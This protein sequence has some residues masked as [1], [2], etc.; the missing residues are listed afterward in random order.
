MRFALTAEQRQF[1]DAVHD[2]LARADVPAAARAWAAGDHAPALAI[3]RALAATG[4]PAL[5]V[6]GSCGGLGAHPV[7]LV[8]ACEELGHHPLPGPV[9]ESVAAVPA[10]LATLRGNDAARDWLAALAGGEL[11]ATLAIPPLLP[12]ALDADAAGLVLLAS[13][14][15][16]GT[17]A[18]WQA[19][20]RAGHRS[21]DRARRLFDVYPVRAVEAEPGGGVAAATTAATRYGTLASA[22][23]LLGAGRGLLD[24]AVTH[25]KTREQFGKPIGAFQAV[26]HALADVLIGLEFARPILY[27]AAVSLGANAPTTTRDISAARV[28]CADAARQAA[29]TALQVH[30]AIG[31][32]LECDI[33]L[34][35][36]KVRA[37]SATWGSQS[38]HRTTVL[39]A[40]T[41]ERTGPWR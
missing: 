30:G 41:E 31:Y 9:A 34:W 22:A 18:I 12:C 35:L 6:P 37:L 2:L 23:V 13:D 15:G 17:L 14:A 1:G 27:A 7:D 20:P 10:L 19:Q 24:A 36:A 29:R 32:T 38:E 25:A 40:L 5:A 3:W 21:A 8:V 26:K 4:V 11:I 33:S 28:A 39:A 16:P